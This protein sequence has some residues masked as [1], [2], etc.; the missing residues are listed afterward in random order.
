MFFFFI[1]SLP[2]SLFLPVCLFLDLSHAV[3]LVRSFI[4]GRLLYAKKKNLLFFRWYLDH[5]I[6]FVEIWLKSDKNESAFLVLQ[7]QLIQ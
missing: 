6:K 1:R 5:I 3:S 7:I 4:A 2:P